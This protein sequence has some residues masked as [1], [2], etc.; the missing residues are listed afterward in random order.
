VITGIGHEKDLT[1]S[2]IVAYRA[3]KT[4]TAVADWLVSCVYEAEDHLVKMGT[5]ISTLALSIIEENR[6]RIESKKMQLIP[7]ARLMVSAEKERLSAKI[8]SIINIGKEYIVREE[9]T[10]V[11]HTARL[12]SAF[13]G[14][15]TLTNIRINRSLSD[16]KAMTFK[17]LKDSGVL[18]EACNNALNILSPEKVLRR[19]YSITSIK[20]K[21]ILS[22][23]EVK[24]GDTIDTQFSKGSIKSKVT[25]SKSYKITPGIRKL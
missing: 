4:P 15:I 9:L 5:E 1:V 25:K 24:T 7:V 17:S 18:I 10:P 3:E 11:N 19:G 20:G 23:E 13:K 14:V 16:L 2:D 6:G 8:I 21:V 12:N 22:M